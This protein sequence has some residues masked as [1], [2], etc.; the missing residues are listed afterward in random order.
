M[1]RLHENQVL[2]RVPLVAHQLKV[3]VG[4]VL[5]PPLLMMKVTKRQVVSV[6]GNTFSN[7]LSSMEPNPLR[8]SGLTFVTVQSIIVGTGKTD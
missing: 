5:S 3:T 6:L 8:L 4:L 2:H 1:K 7:P